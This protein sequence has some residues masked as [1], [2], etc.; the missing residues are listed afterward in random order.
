MRRSFCD[1]PED[2]GSK[3]LRNVG[4]KLPVN[5]VPHPEIGSPHYQTCCHTA[6]SAVRCDCLVV[7]I[8]AFR[9]VCVRACVP[10]TTSTCDH[11]SALFF[12]VVMLS[13]EITA[14]TFSF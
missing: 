5:T 3:L 11:D 2:G 8:G 12:S 1:Y 10:A 13:K 4:N 14:S 7:E 9:C 6:C